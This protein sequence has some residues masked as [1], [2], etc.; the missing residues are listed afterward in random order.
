LRRPSE[1]VRF[2]PEADVRTPTF[3]PVVHHLE[4]VS[5]GEDSSASGRT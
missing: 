3:R 5:R 2:V 4:V 1:S